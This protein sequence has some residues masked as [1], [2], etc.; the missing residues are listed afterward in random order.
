MQEYPV[1][2]VVCIT[3]IV[4][5]MAFGLVDSMVSKSSIITR[6]LNAVS[7]GDF[8]AAALS[9]IFRFGSD[10]V[11]PCN[12]IIEK[13]DNSARIRS[14]EDKNNNVVG[15]I[16]PVSSSKEAPLIRIYTRGNCTFESD[17]AL[18]EFI[19]SL[20]SGI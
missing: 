8:A 5:M 11:K 1:S 16:V 9:P 4:S 20:A 3:V 2:K 6:A 17:V 14:I 12:L 15:I 10:Q 13:N 7:E 19:Q 18:T